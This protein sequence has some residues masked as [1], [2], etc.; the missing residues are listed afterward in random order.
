[1]G[2]SALRGRADCGFRRS[3]PPIAVRTG[4]GQAVRRLPKPPLEVNAINKQ[5]FLAE[6]AKLLTFMYEEDRQKALAMYSK[7]FED[8]DNEQ[9]LIQSL[10]SPTRQA[11]VVA[12]AYDAK[13]RR[14]QVTSTSRD[15][16][17]YDA[18]SGGTPEY[19]LAIQ[20]VYEAYARQ[21]GTRAARLDNQFSLFADEEPGDDHLFEE[22]FPEVM[23]PENPPRNTA[24]AVAAQAVT[25]EEYEDEEPAPEEEVPAEPAAEAP[26]PPAAEESLSPE[27]KVDAFMADF[28]LDGESPDAQAQ[29][30]TA[31]EPPAEQTA[32]EA[33]QPE[34]PEETV[35]RTP[36]IPDTPAELSAILEKPEPSR[37]VVRKSRPVLLVLFILLFVPITLACILLL[38]IPAALS[39]VTAVALIA[40]GAVTLIAAFGSGFGVLADILVMIGLAVIILALGLLFLW[41][42]IWF[43]GGPIVGLVRG[44]MALGGKWCYKEVL[45]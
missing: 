6:L 18:A 32:E 30:E 25:L 23:E 10:V 8:A 33:P 35:R 4:I 12:R 39:L 34:A 44:V 2:S 3:L 37:T 42:F 15:E 29:P 43:I 9:G 22:T 26:A 7:M 21:N 14:L 40:A 28:S 38:L 41:L 45:E 27:E 11:V 24:P 16:G 36:V 19:V 17:A 1:M 20:K 5:K 13:D 31:E